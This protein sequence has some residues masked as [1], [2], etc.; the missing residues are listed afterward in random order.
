[1]RARGVRNA[2]VVWEG[3]YELEILV[4]SENNEEISFN[5]NINGNERIFT[6]AGESIVSTTIEQKETGLM[7][8][9]IEPEN[10][11][12]IVCGVILNPVYNETMS[13]CLTGQVM[14]FSM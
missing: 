7:S 11:S 3:A 5:V 12:I 10:G 13:I 1:M 6:T 2:S 9:I 8:L 4:A 14:M